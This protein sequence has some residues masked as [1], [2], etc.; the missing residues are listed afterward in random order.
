MDKTLKH[1]ALTVTI[2]ARAAAA[3]EWQLVNGG[4]ANAVAIAHDE[5]EAI[6][7]VRDGLK[8]AHWDLDEIKQI[9]CPTERDI[10]QLEPLRQLVE[11]ARKYGVGIEVFPAVRA[12]DSGRAN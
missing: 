5:V 7:I 1:F 9:L 8:R 10:E 3:P 4:F 2:R 6:E 12:P 11:N